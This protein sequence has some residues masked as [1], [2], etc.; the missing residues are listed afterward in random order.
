VAHQST[1][2]DQ[3]S[4]HRHL[5]TCNDHHL[6]QPR[7][8]DT[9]W[10]ALSSGRPVAA[11]KSHNDDNDEDEL[12]QE[13]AR[14]FKHSNSSINRAISLGSVHR[15]S[16]T[17]TGGGGLY[18]RPDGM[19]RRFKE[20][21]SSLAP[22]GL[23]HSVLVTPTR[24]LRGR[25][26]ASS[27][28]H[29][30]RGERSRD[31]GHPWQPL[32][33]HV[34]TPTE[35]D[36]CSAPSSPDGGG[37]LTRSQ[38]IWRHATRQHQHEQPVATSRLATAGRHQSPFERQHSGEAGNHSP[39]YPSDAT[40]SP[41]PP[42]PPP[43]LPPVN[44]SSKY[45]S[46]DRHWTRA[47]GQHHQHAGG[48]YGGQTGRMFAGA[49]PQFGQMP[50]DDD[51]AGS[52]HS[53]LI[54]Q[55]R[56]LERVQSLH[57]RQTLTSG[58]SLHEFF[59][60]PLS[61]QLSALLARSLADQ[62]SSQQRPKRQTAQQSPVLRLEEYLATLNNTS[63]ATSSR[64][65]FKG[66]AGNNRGQRRQQPNGTDMEGTA[67]ERQQQTAQAASG[68]VGTSQQQSAANSRGGTLR[69]HQNVKLQNLQ[70]LI[71]RLQELHNRTMLQQQFGGADDDDDDDDGLDDYEAD[72]DEA[73]L[74]ELNTDGE[75]GAERARLGRQRPSGP[76]LVQRDGQRQRSA[77]SRPV[78]AGR[79]AAGGSQASDD[80]DK[81]ATHETGA[82]RAAGRIAPTRRQ[83]R[84]NLRR[85]NSHKSRRLDDDEDD[86][87]G[88]GLGRSART[89]S[90][91]SMRNELVYSMS[92][93]EDGRHVTRKLLASSGGMNAK[94][95][96]GRLA[97]HSQ[98][99][100]TEPTTSTANANTSNELMTKGDKNGQ[101]VDATQTADATSSI[102]ANERCR[103]TDESSSRT[104]DD[105]SVGDAQS[106]PEAVAPRPS[107]P[108]CRQQ[109]DHVMDG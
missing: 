53:T 52:V 72:D 101:Q 19:T 26:R 81:D 2:S 18:G 24:R 48:D 37:A 80:E 95:D 82:S 5:P 40:R 4:S 103:E 3:T 15:C 76:P 91:S 25:S 84:P 10:T 22:G 96:G 65:S 83:T 98:W 14:P 61:I 38:P 78:A 106:P 34:D 85:S 97:L 16:Q 28:G 70:S 99:M 31:G 90:R 7:Q 20:D 56:Q 50:L 62:A 66:V 27:L 51:A 88:D 79:K 30:L 41:T 89:A 107:A 21:G 35:F 60:L 39:V 45:K 59:S 73:K 67:V 8:S 77:R 108:S 71:S 32:M 13:V 46:I 105:Q 29:Q 44:S 49:E 93:S 69:K 17:A 11:S 109:S 43:P 64:R 68:G 104:T 58:A 42:P 54:E 55:L 33:G 57:Q 63:V 6:F 12:L 87:D 47:N 9:V 75:L 102:N 92:D 94:Q 1:M 36:S 86:G 74:L 100:A 23:D